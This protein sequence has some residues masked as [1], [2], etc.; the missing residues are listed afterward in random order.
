M[1][2]PSAAAP[3]PPPSYP[4]AMYPPPR[5]EGMGAN[6]LVL[7]IG[8]FMGALIFAG[9]LS[10]HAALLIPVPCPQCSPSSDPAII[11][12]RDTIRILGWVSVI[13]M[14]MAVSLAVAMA[15]IVG[16]S[17]SEISDGTRRGVFIFATVFL[18]VWLLFSWTA[19]TIFRV[20]IPF[21]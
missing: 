15:W 4:P 5:R 14:D 3:E 6:T 2:E 12:Y 13:A 19:Y 1:M 17:K 21:G 16:G 9:T 10:F 20:L 18:A 7:L 8:L 11:A